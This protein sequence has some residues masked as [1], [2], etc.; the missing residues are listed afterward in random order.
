MPAAPA[1]PTTVAAGNT[2]HVGHTN[3][4]HGVI[5]AIY[6]ASIGATRTGAFTIAQSD[7][8]DVI[9]MN[10]SSSVPVTVPSRAAGTTVELVR[11]NATFTLAASGTTF[12]PAAGGTPRAV[13]SSVS[14]LWLTTTSV[15]VGGDLT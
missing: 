4:V 12:I 10:N 7:S 13:G 8:G 5:N 1:L 3:T 6:L 11:T 9:P 15:L 14:L 2:G